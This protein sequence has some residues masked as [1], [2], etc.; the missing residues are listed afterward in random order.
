MLVHFANGLEYL[1]L[2]I[3]IVLS[4]ILC[5][6][7]RKLAPVLHLIEIPREDRL[8]QRSVPVGGGLGWMVAFLILVAA[9]S[10][11]VN[12][13]TL[14]EGLEQH[15]LGM[16]AK[17][18]DMSWICAGAA[19]L[20]LLGL[21]DDIRPVPI[22]IKL[23]LEFVVAITL[24]FQVP[25]VLITAFV[26]NLALN[27]VFTVFWIVFLVNSFNLLDHADGSSSVTAIA[28]FVGLVLLS[29]ISGQVFVGLISLLLVGVLLGFLVQNFPPAKIFMGDAGSLPLGYFVGV[30]TGLFTF[31]SDSREV[32][33]VFVPL[34]LLLVP[35]YD[36]ASVCVIRFRSGKPLWVGDKNHISHRLLDRGWSARRVVIALFVMTL[37]G[38]L[39]SVLVFVLSPPW[40]YLPL[41]LALLLIFYVQRLER[42]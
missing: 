24:A 25:D 13:F 36:S 20:M 14:P 11:W 3:A 10:W 26:D 34:C 6:G 23:V 9:G 35:V 41:C 37:V 1:L 42:R 7:V 28:V 38:A 8:S 29:F 12:N 5:L 15:R 2:F 18:M 16:M 4:S 33:T 31:Y 22:T 30:L 21:F 19:V 39:L 40:V 32:T 17:I 27:R